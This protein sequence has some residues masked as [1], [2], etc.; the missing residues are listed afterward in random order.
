MISKAVSLPS[1]GQILSIR[2]VI[3][4][5]LIFFC[6][7]QVWFSFMPLTMIRL[8][9]LVGTG[10]LL[11]FIY[12]NKFLVNK[13]LLIVILINFAFGTYAAFLS[14]NTD[15][16]LA[17]FRLITNLT[18]FMGMSILIFRLMKN[19]YGQTLPLG[20][21]LDYW[22]FSTIIQLA[23][24]IPCFVNHSMFEWLSSIQ[25]IGEKDL[26]RLDLINV[27]MIGLGNAFFGA[28]FNYAVDLLVL[29]Y[30]PYTGNSYI[31]SH[32]WLY[33]ILIVSTLVV[34]VLS[35]RTF[36]I[37]VLFVVLFLVIV[38][39]N[40]KFRFVIK[41]VK[42]ILLLGI[43]SLFVWIILSKYIEN[44]EMV[45]NWAFELFINMSS[46][47]NIETSS[48]DKMIEMYRFPATIQTWLFGDG[49]M[50]YANGLYYMRTDIGFIRLIFYWGLPMTIMYY[51]YR[52]YCVRVIYRHSFS[53]LMKP[54]MICYLLFE[55][56]ANAKGLIFGDFFLSYMIIYTLIYD[57]PSI[58][59]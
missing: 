57:R 53:R 43:L 52:F 32:K 24:T 31:Y 59:T 9:Q 54:F 49:L 29:A 33:W 20:K 27:R 21:A 51:L 23:I 56:A 5:L 50:Q 41:S 37:G 35:A 4:I 6:R 8:L 2:S 38:N 14:Y 17:V 30:M 1:I 28:G 11:L 45:S 12:R 13:E 22:I 44:L 34:G 25:T 55:Y 3:C 26:G 19:D 40:R 7:Y 16:D 39:I 47:G 15:Q 42:V 36:I 58:D 10:Y 48:S 46:N 18:F